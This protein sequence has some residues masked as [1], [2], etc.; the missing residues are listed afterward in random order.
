MGAISNNYKQ[1]L[2]I[3][4]EDVTIDE[5]SL[6]EHLVALLETKLEGKILFYRYSKKWL[7]SYTHFTK[8]IDW[9]C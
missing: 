3:T 1:I 9:F 7:I 5:E 2:Q 8:K 4:K 6:R